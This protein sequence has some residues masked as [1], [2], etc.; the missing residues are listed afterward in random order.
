M[1]VRSSTTRYELLK[2]RFELQV[3][4][5]VRGVCSLSN[6]PRITWRMGVMRGELG[7]MVLAFGREYGPRMI[8]GLPGVLGVDPILRSEYVR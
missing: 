7:N 1:P 5:G 4:A 6:V 3:R 2:C 8:S